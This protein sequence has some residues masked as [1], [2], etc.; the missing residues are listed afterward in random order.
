MQNTVPDTEDVSEQ[1]KPGPC[2]HGGTGYC[3]YMLEEGG[4]K[5]IINK[6]ILC[7]D[8]YSKGNAML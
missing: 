6:T 3:V 4:I 5:Q 2:S 7:T 1:S 8:K